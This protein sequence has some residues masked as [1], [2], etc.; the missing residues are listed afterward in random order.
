MNGIQLSSVLA[1][2]AGI[3]IIIFPNILE[4]LVAIVLIVAGI[5]GLIFGAKMNKFWRVKID[6]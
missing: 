3:M 4:T 6:K 5:N 2:L 1:I